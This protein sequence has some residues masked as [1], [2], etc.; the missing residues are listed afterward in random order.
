MEIGDRVVC[1][2]DG[3]SIGMHTHTLT[4]RERERERERERLVIAWYAALTAPP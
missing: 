4:Q 3:A 1:R 2:I